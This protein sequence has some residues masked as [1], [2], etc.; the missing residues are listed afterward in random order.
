MFQGCV[1]KR[2]PALHQFGWQIRKACQSLSLNYKYARPAYQETDNRIIPGN[3]HSDLN[4]LFFLLCWTSFPIWRVHFDVQ[5]LDTCGQHKASD[6]FCSQWIYRRS[7]KKKN[8]LDIFGFILLQKRPV[9]VYAKIQN[10][11]SSFGGKNL[12]GKFKMLSPQDS[13]KGDY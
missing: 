12:A 7:Q 11:F 3:T 6:C 8:L 4:F 1:R 2:A 13:Y 9:S 5:S 10:F